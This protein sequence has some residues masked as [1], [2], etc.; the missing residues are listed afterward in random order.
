MTWGAFIL[1]SF[2]CGSIP[3]GLLIARAKGIDIRAHGSKNIGA[4]NVGR[5]LG[6]RLGALCFVL[7]FLK[8]FAP[9][10]AAGLWSGLLGEW[11]P[12]DRSIRLWLLVMVASILGHIYSPWVGFKGGKGV[13]T[14]LGAMVGFF[15]L[16][17]F[18]ALG[19]MAVWLV[20]IGVWRYVSLASCL[21]AVSIPILAFGAPNAIAWVR[22]WQLA[23][24]GFVV[25]WPV[26]ACSA[27]LAALVIYRHRT[28][29]A[30]IRAGTEPR[31]R[32]SRSE[33]HP[34]KL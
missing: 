16:L 6:R 1:V 4:T 24:F 2:L 13:A 26:I 33:P 34:P 21:A 14:S 15:P 22:G 3:F 10:I 9:T 29:L 32:S 11:S 30:R 25:P 23:K 27:L 12:D 17:T 7:D 18:P 20:A 8:G 31:V 19:A 28:N 5:V